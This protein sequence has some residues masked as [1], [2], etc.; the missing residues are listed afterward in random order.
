MADSMEYLTA[1]QIA[2]LKSII[3]KHRK[4]WQQTSKERPSYAPKCTFKMTDTDPFFQRTRPMN[5]TLRAALRTEI[6][7]QL[8]MGVIR[9]SNSPYGSPVLLVPKPGS[10]KLRFVV[11]LRALNS[12]IIAD[13]YSLPNI[14][15]I[16][17]SVEG[18]VMFT[19]L[20]LSNAFWSVELEEKSRRFTSFTTSDGSYEWVQ[21]PQGLKVASA[22]FCRYLNAALG[23]LRWQD[24]L[25][26]LDDLLVATKDFDTHAQALAK[27]FLKLEE[28]GLTM[29]PKKCH[30]AAREAS[31][32]GQVISADGVRPNPDKIKAIDA[33]TLPD[34]VSGMRTALGGLGYYKGSLHLPVASLGWAG[35]LLVS[36]AAWPDLVA[37]MYLVLVGGDLACYLCGFI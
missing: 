21:M 16:L 24:C 22:V 19:A 37:S 13:G 7:K 36:N 25:C 34:S 29:S 17:S 3:I 20:D 23:S 5:P 18:G 30:I 32:I 14:E 4:L 6:E 12:K 15:E 33:L 9:P 11:D 1:G 27:I 31:F 8:D 35:K 2:V 28:Y 26:Y 10:T